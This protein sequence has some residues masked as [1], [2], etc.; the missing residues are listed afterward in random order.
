MLQ[1]FGKIV[2]CSKYFKAVL[3]NYSVKI[4]NSIYIIKD[5]FCKELL[6]SILIGVPLC[7]EL[8]AELLTLYLS[9][10]S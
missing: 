7:S 3:I 5:F 8:E 6:Y 2:V 1:A 10:S 9:V 4:L